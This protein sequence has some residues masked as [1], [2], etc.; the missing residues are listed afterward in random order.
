[1]RVGM[2]DAQDGWM[3]YPVHTPVYGVYTHVYAHV[4]TP[5]YGDTPTYTPHVYTHVY[6]HVH[7]C[8]AHVVGSGA[9]DVVL[10][11]DPQWLIIVHWCLSSNPRIPTTV[12]DTP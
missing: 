8:H 12:E 6:T 10:A 2:Y 9:I 4:H 11:S 1:M 7:R 3:R 5:E